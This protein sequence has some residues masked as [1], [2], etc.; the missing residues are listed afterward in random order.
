MEVSKYQELFHKFRSAQKHKQH[1][2]KKK[3][4]HKGV[5]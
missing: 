1:L 3:E 4:F 2:Y 5:N